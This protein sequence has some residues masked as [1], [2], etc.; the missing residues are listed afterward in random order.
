[1]PPSKLILGVPYYGYDWPVTSDAP[2]ATV[3][4]S[5]SKCGGVWSVT[6]AGAM[7]LARGAPRCRPPGGHCARAARSSPTGTPTE[8]TFRQVYFEDE[9]SAAEKY[10]YAIATGLAGVGIWTLDNDR[11]YD[12]DVQ[13]HQ[14]QVLRPDP[15]RVDERQRDQRSA[16]SG[17]ERQC[18]ATSIGSSNR[19]QRPGPR[20]G[21]LADPRPQRP[22]AQEGL[23][24]APPVP[25]RDPHASRSR[26]RSASPRVSPRGPTA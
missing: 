4:T 2:N 15:G 9:V 5:P 22:P 14:G 8:Q 21:R 11:G 7:N 24:R 19:R 18:H 17:R 13:R 1:M 26:R 25:R 6:Y 16:R 10:D 23:V 3:Q 20:H 12:R